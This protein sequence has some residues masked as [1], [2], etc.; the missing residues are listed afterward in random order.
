MLPKTDWL[1]LVI[2]GLF[3]FAAIVAA[4]FNHCGVLVP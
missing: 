1:P 3:V 4:V 2:V